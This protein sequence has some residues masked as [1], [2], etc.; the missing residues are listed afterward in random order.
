MSFWVE[1]VSDPFNLLYIAWL[2]W[3]LPVAAILSLMTWISIHS[4]LIFFHQSNTNQVN[5]LWTCHF[6]WSLC[7]TLSI[8]LIFLH[9][10]WYDIY[11]L[12]QYHHWL[13]AWVSTPNSNFFRQFIA[14]QV[15]QWWTCLFWV[16]LVLDPSNLILHGWYH[17][18]SLSTCCCHDTTI[19]HV[20]SIYSQLNLF[21]SIH[22][23]S[24]QSMMDIFILSEAC[25]G[26][27]NLDI[28][29]LVPS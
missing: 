10:C 27:F 25:V 14:D 21:S 11:L 12:L 4:Q 26:P 17:H 7:Q 29:W 24:S 8:F 28:T 15:N 20:M 5:Q 23:W 2:V 3:H 6:E 1:L 9:G 16:K 18:S 19:D 22:C 13:C